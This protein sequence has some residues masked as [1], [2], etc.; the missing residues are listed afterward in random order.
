MTILVEAFFPGKIKH[1]KIELRLHLIC[2][3]Y[4]LRVNS[5]EGTLTTLFGC[6]FLHI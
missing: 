2:I 1:S 6:L 3:S 4:E 5:A